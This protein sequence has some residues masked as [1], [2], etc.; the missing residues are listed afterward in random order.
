MH[1][2][3]WSVRA[4]HTICASRKL[5]CH[6]WLGSSDWTRNASFRLFVQVGSRI[7]II[8]FISSFYYIE[9]NRNYRIEYSFRL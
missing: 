6:D 1:W 8:A 2:Y 5:E 3:R 9:K 7:V 4:G